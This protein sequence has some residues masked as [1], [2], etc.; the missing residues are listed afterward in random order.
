ML[1]SLHA[2]AAAEEFM[3]ISEIL[4]PEFNEEMKSTR[5][6]LERV[7]EDK[8]EYKPHEKSMTMGRLASHVAELPVWAV[9]TFQMDVLDLQPGQQ[10]F[11]AKSHKDLLENFDK[12]VA[13]ARGLIAG[14]TDEKLGEIWTLKFAGKTIV[15]MPR[16]KVLRSMVMNHMIHHR[17][18]LSVYLR[19]VDM[20]VPGMY[21]PSADEM[22]FWSAQNA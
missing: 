3:T 20:E 12:Q 22:K 1:F 14:A 8:F 19:L 17:A 5:K 21:G 11:L 9:H 4:L 13:E 18:Q 2:A 10:P 7:P 16:A 6:M 15:A